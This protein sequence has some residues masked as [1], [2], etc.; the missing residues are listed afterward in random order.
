MARMVSNLMVKIGKDLSGMSV[1]AAGDI[2]SDGYDD[3]LIGAYLYPGGYGKGRSYIVF[4]GPKVGNSGVIALSSL[5]GVNGFKLDGETNGDL[6]S[7]SGA[8]AGDIN[9]DGHDDLLIGA[10]GYPG[11]NFKGRSY[12]IFGGPGVGKN[13]LIELSS[14]NGSNGFKLDGENTNDHSGASVSAVGD[15]NGDNYDDLIIGAFGYPAEKDKGRNYVIFGGPGVGSDGM[16][17][18]SSLKGINGFKCDGEN[19][20][21]R[22]GYTVSSAGD[23]NSDGY[24]DLLIGAY[25]YPQGNSTG[26]TYVVLGGSEIGNTELFNLSE[27]NGINGFKIDGENQGD[28]ESIALS[29]I[30]DFN[31]DGYDDLLMGAFIYPGYGKG[32]SYVVFGGPRIGEG[33]ILKLANLNGGNGFKLDGEYNGD[34]SGISVSSAGDINCD[35]V[36]DLLIGAHQYTNGNFYG[37]SYVV[38]GDI[39][40]VIVNNSLRLV[41]NETVILN[42]SHLA[43]YDRNH[44]NNTLWFVLTNLTHGQFEVVDNPGVIIGNFTQQ[45]I[46]DG[47]ICF[48]HDGGPA[49]TYNITVSSSGLA[50]TGPM[51]ADIIFSNFLIENNQLIINQG[52]AVILTA[53]NLKAAFSGKID[54]NL[55]F[56]VSDLAHGQFEFLMSPN[57]P[58]L[59][60]QQQNVTDEMVQFIHDN[61]TSAP[62]YRIAVTNGV[63]TDPPQAAVIDFDANPVL[64]NNRLVINQGQIVRLTAEILNAT[65]PWRQ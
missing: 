9:G 28:A 58:I 60:F 24:A 14:L 51:S 19:N 42:A 64:V 34:A 33:E 22:S 55:T 52:Q 2:N 45:Q 20:G 35:G 26:R 39:P 62:R 32:R 59:I 30:G 29:R 23:I 15:V 10:S 5:N 37:R 43:A 53:N 31:G 18:L 63:L 61:T 4:G 13:G 17:N 1:S 38:F 47:F 40:P 54:G 16:Y 44:D 27:L 12:I 6:S 49:P 65:H 21:D 50:W 36:A 56:L 7:F 46:L 3:L 8:L 11:P 25:A 48:V 41:N 57:Q